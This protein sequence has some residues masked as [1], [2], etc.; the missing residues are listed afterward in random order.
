MEAAP[1]FV[2]IDKYKELSE[3]LSSVDEQI[4]QASSLLDRLEKLKEQEDAQLSAWK[5]SLDDV[6]A[7]SAE[8]NKQLFK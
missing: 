3:T 8:L 2:K 7:R 1:L 4:S 5:A 6:K